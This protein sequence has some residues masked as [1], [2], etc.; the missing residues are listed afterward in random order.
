V[1]WFC[2]LWAGF[3]GVW[4]PLSIWRLKFPQPQ[5]VLLN[6]T[7]SY[8]SFSSTLVL[9]FGASYSMHI[10]ISFCLSSVLLI[11]SQ[12]LF[13]SLFI[14]HFKICPSFPHPFLC[15]R[16]MLYLFTLGVQSYYLKILKVFKIFNFYL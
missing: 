8:L 9:I 1:F 2:L 7:F 4:C 14:F 11:F 15:G 10:R 3:P 16:Y 6:Y 5:E 12:I 13:I